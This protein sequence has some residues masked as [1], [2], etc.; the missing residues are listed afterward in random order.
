[1]KSPKRR[2]FAASC[3]NRDKFYYPYNYAQIVTSA[4][5][6]QAIRR[7]MGLNR[8]CFDVMPVRYEVCWKF[9]FPVYLSFFFQNP[10]HL[11]KKN[12][13]FEFASSRNPPSKNSS[14]KVLNWPRSCLFWR[15]ACLIRGL[16]KCFSVYLSFF[17]QKAKHVF[18][19]NCAVEFVLSRNPPSKNSSRS[20]QVLLS[21]KLQR[22]G[23]VTALA[24]A[25]R[26]W[27]GYVHMCFDVMPVRYEVCWNVFQFIYLFFFQKP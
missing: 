25:M 17:F 4:P 9:F 7:W 1:M 13:T 21:I 24:Q 19:W 2:Q 6:A 15:D 27:R 10:K 5:L 8:A 12:H 14:D 11:F 3:S 20:I 18:K 16:S 26:C 22:A 23:S